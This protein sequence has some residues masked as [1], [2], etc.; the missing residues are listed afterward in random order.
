MLEQYPTLEKVDVPELKEA[1]SLVTVS[2]LKSS[3]QPTAALR[4]ARYLAARDKGLKQFEAAGYRVVEGDQWSLTP[5]VRLFAGAM[6]R[7]AIE[8]TIQRFEERE[9]CRVTR[10][11]N[12]CGILV[13]Q[14][15]TGIDAV[16]DAYFACDATFMKQVTDLFLDQSTI[17]S[18]QL[19][20]I[21]PKGNPKG[22]KTMKDL[23][24]PG[25]RLGVGHEQQCAMGALTGRTLDELGLRNE[26]RKNV[27]AESPTGDMLVNQ[28][29]TGSLDAVI[30][31]ISNA[32]SAQDVLEAYAI[33]IPCA[34]A[35]QPMAVG[36][37]SK[38]KYLTARLMA[39]IGSEESKA[40]FV[41]NGFGWKVGTK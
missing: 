1:T 30:A 27:K 28:L 11:Y 2:V 19:V 12:G 16:P 24:Q 36:K 15:K 34:V 32:A 20:I 7:P 4:F 39:A 41:A 33:D 18:N 22:V 37:G 29:R 31:Y 10:V 3:K 21:V 23:A 17:S 13:G 5:E 26:V 6:L 14:M 9:G 40:L 25:L 8:Q 35:T 38:Q